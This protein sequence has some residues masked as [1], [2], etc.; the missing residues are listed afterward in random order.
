MSSS[1]VKQVM[2]QACAERLDAVPSQ[3]PRCSRSFQSFRQNG[4]WAGHLQRRPD[5]Y[6]AAPHP[7]KLV[8][9]LQLPVS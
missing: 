5:T 6:T 7:S 9:H 3:I 1:E 2:D 8:V 4:L